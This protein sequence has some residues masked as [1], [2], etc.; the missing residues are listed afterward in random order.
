MCVSAVEAD[1]LAVVEELRNL[2]K[3]GVHVIC[4]DADVNR[5]KYR[6]AREFYIGTDNIQ[7]GRAL[8]LAAKQLLESRKVT[9]GE[10]VEF[11]GYVGAQNAKES[12]GRL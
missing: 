10:Y 1:N 2:R 8:G 9:H 6:D 11:V 3:K 4:F 12:H 5:A 7:A